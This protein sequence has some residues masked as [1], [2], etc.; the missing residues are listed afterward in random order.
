[1]LLHRSATAPSAS[2]YSLRFFGTGANEADRVKIKLDARAKPV[3]VGAADFTIEFWLKASA[4]DNTQP[5]II[6]GANVDWI[7]GNIILDNDTSGTPDTGDYGFSLA[8]GFVA[9]GCERAGGGARTI[10]G[11]TDVADGAWHHIALTRSA[12]TGL[13][14]L[15]VDGVA[16]ASGTGPTGNLS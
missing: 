6:P 3:D 1:V 11:S 16:D 13:L 10:L 7:N 5:A 9:F 15:W 8:G 4:G 14:T 2:G 12:T